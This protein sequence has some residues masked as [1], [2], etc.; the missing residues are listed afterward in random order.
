[1]RN[2]RRPCIEIMTLARTVT[3]T[4]NTEPAESIKDSA[5]G[6]ADSLNYRRTLISVN[7]AT[8]RGRPP[9]STSSTRRSAD[10]YDRTR[11][12]PLPPRGSDLAIG[13]LSGDMP[14]LVW[15]IAGVCSFDDHRLAIL[16]RSLE[17]L[18][19]LRSERSISLWSMTRRDREQ[20]KWPASARVLS[21]KEH[22]NPLASPSFPVS[23]TIHF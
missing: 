15:E 12:S 22:T 14:F 11:I 18:A 19:N 21:R 3:P 8:P 6:S 7:F 16:S 13:H 9:N 1:M 17:K 5:L 2:E 10:R 4:A 20:D 23:K